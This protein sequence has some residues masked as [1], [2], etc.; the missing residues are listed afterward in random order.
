MC[1]KKYDCVVTPDGENSTYGIMFKW[2]GRNSV[3]LDVG[4]ARGYFGEALRKYRDSR[5]FGIEY[6]REMR[7]EARARGVYEEIVDCDLNAATPETFAAWR[8]KFDRIIMGDVLE[9]LMSPL[10]A[11]TALSSCLAPGGSFLV[12]LP[13]VAHASVKAELLLNRFR[14]TE[15]GLLD[16]T[17]LRFFTAESVA[18]FMTDSAL[19]IADAGATMMGIEGFSDGSAFGSLEPAV[20]RRIL[21]NVHSYICQYV[22]RAVPSQL[23]AEELRR[24]NLGKLDLGFDDFPPVLRQ[25]ALE[26]LQKFHCLD[27]GTSD[28]RLTGKNFDDLVI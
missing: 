26:Q 12:S 28:Y 18:N 24:R 15:Q 22:C 20:L 16:R 14:Y 25:Y 1:A 2:I 27:C 11:I 4:C 3:V 8:G 23:P 21:S 17:H 19:E 9:H 5:C 7:E 6:D 13:N 10:S